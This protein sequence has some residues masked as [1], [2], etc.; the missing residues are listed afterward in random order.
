M[1]S[2]AYT[3]LVPTTEVGAVCLPCSEY[4][5]MVDCPECGDVFCVFCSEFGCESCGAAI[6]FTR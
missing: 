3:A 1:N 5:G 4:K 6:D 2:I